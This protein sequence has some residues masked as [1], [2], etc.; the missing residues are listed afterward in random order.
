MHTPTT[1][2]INSNAKKH[3]AQLD[4]TLLI[5]FL[6][7]KSSLFACLQ[8]ACQSLTYWKNPTTD[9]DLNLTFFFLFLFSP[10]S[11][12]EHHAIPNTIFFLPC[13]ILFPALLWNSS[14]DP[15]I[16]SS[17]AFDRNSGEKRRLNWLPEEGTWRHRCWTLLHGILGKAQSCARGGLH[18]MW[19]TSFLPR[20]VKHWT[21]FLERWLML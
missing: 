11:Y 1:N 3:M 12:M 5:E 21:G 17:L 13:V 14:L 19:G 2:A 20:M 10:L 18:L 6:Q 4:R 16:N 15:G 9:F 7:P 8:D